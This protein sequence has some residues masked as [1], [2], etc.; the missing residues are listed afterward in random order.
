MHL[1]GRGRREWKALR[2]YPSSVL[3]LWR[4]V[5][6]LFELP[7][8]III[9]FPSASGKLTAVKCIG[10]LVSLKLSKAETMRLARCLSCQAT[11]YLCID[12]YVG[13]TLLKYQ[14]FIHSYLVLKKKDVS[15]L[16]FLFSEALC[17]LTHL[18]LPIALA[19]SKI[20]NPS[21]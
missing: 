18:T 21:F 19:D 10:E 12:R 3:V 4:F 2:Q 13:I 15:S 1:S 8:F 9:I 17:H 16:S 14:C 11:A 6:L 5:K 20:V 7:M